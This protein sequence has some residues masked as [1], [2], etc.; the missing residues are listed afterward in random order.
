[1]LGDPGW[2]SIYGNGLV[3]AETAVAAAI[4]GG[5]DTDMYVSDISM[6]IL[7]QGSSDLARAIITV[8]DDQGNPV[9]NAQVSITWSGLISSTAQGVTGSDGKVTFN[10]AKT[11]STGTF[12]ITVTDITHFSYTYNP[13]LNVETSD[14]ISN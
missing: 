11:R 5:G 8:L 12:T 7:Q 4:G 13:A 3:N 1:D 6:S 14:S 9:S 2:D 10:S